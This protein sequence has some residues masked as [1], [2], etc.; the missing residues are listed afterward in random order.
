MTYSKRAK[1]LLGSTAVGL[2]LLASPVSVEFVS[3]GNVVSEAFAD[4]SGHSGGGTHQPKGG[5]GKKGGGQKGGGHKGGGGSHGKGGAG[6]SGSSH[7]PDSVSGSSDSV[8]S[9][10]RG[11]KYKGGGAGSAGSSGGKPVWAQEGIPEVEL[12][13]LNMGRAPDHVLKRQL[14]EA[15]TSYD[16]TT[17]N[18]FYNKSYDEMI[19]ILTDKTSFDA[20]TRIDSPPQNIALY[21]DLILNGVTALHE[22]VNDNTPEAIA[23]LSALFLGTASDKEIPITA[24][25]VTAI[26]AIL[27]LPALTDPAP[28]A[29]NADKIRAAILSGHGS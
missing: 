16:P 22:S 17:M 6:S 20:T 26:N 13:R 8:D 18:Q 10:R 5:K 11:P 7:V 29:E 23:K 28:L 9:D 27:G 25:S 19:A 1:Y 3:S 21:K 24:D 4:S 12:G 15:I 14:D 2:A